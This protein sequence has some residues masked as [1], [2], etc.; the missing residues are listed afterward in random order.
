MH[1]GISLAGTI[2]LIL[3]RLI[4]AYLMGNGNLPKLPWLS[5]SNRSSGTPYAH[6]HLC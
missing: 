5:G 4:V 2:H 6:F 1:G 3:N